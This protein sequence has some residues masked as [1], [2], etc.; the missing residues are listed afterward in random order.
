MTTTDEERSITGPE[1]AELDQRQ[2]LPDDAPTPAG[3]VPLIQGT[4]ALY[5]TDSGD[6]VLST[7]TDTMGAQQVKVPRF[8][9]NQARRQNP[10]IAALLDARKAS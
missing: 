9:V 7:W 5:A 10:A 3:P 6:V 2:E 4:F 8:V 1:L